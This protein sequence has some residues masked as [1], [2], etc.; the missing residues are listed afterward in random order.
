[1]RLTDEKIEQFRAIYFKR[2][3]VE[4]SK[5][6]AIEQATKLLQLVML[7]YR[8]M[9]TEEFDEIQARR[10]ANMPTILA[11]ITSPKDENGLE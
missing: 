4:L 9:S 8:P 10:L 5:Q 3:G 7:I 6:D 1:M 2:Y 11:A